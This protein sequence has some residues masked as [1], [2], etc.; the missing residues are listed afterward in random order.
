[1]KNKVILLIIATLLLVLVIN[2]ISAQTDS[3]EKLREAGFTEEALADH[4]GSH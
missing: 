4:C 2:T 1:M 3:I